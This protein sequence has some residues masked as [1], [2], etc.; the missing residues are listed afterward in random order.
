MKKNK[1]SKKSKCFGNLLKLTSLDRISGYVC[2]NAADERVRVINN[3]LSCGIRFKAA[4][5]GSIVLPLSHTTAP[6]KLASLLGLPYERF[7]VRGLPSV[8]FRYKR[9]PG[10]V[11]SAIFAV[12]LTIY[13]SG[14]VWDIKISGNRALSDSQI[15]ALLEK[16]G[17]MP[18]IRRSSLDLDLLNNTVLDAEES[19]GWLSVNFR[20]TTA[21]VEVIEYARPNFDNAAPKPANL[22]AS[23]DG[24]VRE[25]DVVAGEPAVAPGETVKKGELLVGGLY[26]SRRSGYVALHAEGEVIAEVLDR[27]EVRIPLER[28]VKIYTGRSFSDKSLIF[29]GKSLKIS[30]N[31]GKIS[32]EYD[33]INGESENSA[34]GHGFEV[35]SSVKKLELVHGLSLPVKLST[36]VYNEYETE[37]VRITEDA[38]KRLARD[39]LDLKLAAISKIGDVTEK[40]LSEYCDG[41]AYV[42]KA[43]V[44]HTENI[45]VSRPIPMK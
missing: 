21:F 44:Y 16:S 39:A 45:A 37:T 35:T 19:L 6:K 24:V 34:A 7:T 9:R 10:L 14:F 28:A 31:S 1:N 23:R 20:G 40:T 30:K 13:S 5:D 17:C 18:G 25:L 8:I 32:A 2:F 22:V 38:A 26:D 36:T 41:E 11:L 27:F 3:L 42:I 12:F 29:F 43:A 4:P 15:L 33:I